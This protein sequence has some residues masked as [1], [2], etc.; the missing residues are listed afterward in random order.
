MRFVKSPDGETV[1]AVDES[2]KV[3]AYIKKNRFGTHGHWHGWMHYPWC[4]P[5]GKCV[6]AGVSVTSV[7]PERKETR[8]WEH[9]TDEVCCFGNI[10][11]FKER[12][13]KEEQK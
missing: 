13:Q 8:P 2:G 9:W 7:Y 10:K 1:S 4:E 6:W 12:Y 3:V 11:E 5:L